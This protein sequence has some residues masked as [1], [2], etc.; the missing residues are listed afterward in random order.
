MV[1]HLFEDIAKRKAI[2]SLSAPSSPNKSADECG[3]KGHTRARCPRQ[4]DQKTE[5]EQLDECIQLREQRKTVLTTLSINVVEMENSDPQTTP[6]VP[7]L[8]ADNNNGMFDTDMLDSEDD[9]PI[10]G[11]AVEMST[12]GHSKMPIPRTL[13]PN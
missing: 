5:S 8:A 10:D 9:A 11:G 12:I 3:A 1:S 4:D 7:I 13:Q 6:P 2:S